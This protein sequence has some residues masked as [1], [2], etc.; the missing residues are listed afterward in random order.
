MSGP[1]EIWLRSTRV[2]R[3]P[4]GTFEPATVVISAGT[5]TDVVAWDAEPP[6][7]WPGALLDLGARCLLPGLINTHVHLEFSASPRPLGE[8][9][10]E[11]PEERLLRACGNAHRLL[12]SG[13]TT[14][15]DCGS[16]WSLLALARR[17]DLSPVRLPRLVCC[18]P[19]ITCPRGHLHM[20]GG[21]VHDV[22]EMRAHVA[23]AVREGARSVKAMASGGGMTPGTAPEIAS[24]TLDF[25]RAIVAEARLHALPGVAHVLATES[26]RR[27]ALAGFD[28]LE[29][30]AFF[31]RG[32]DGLLVRI[33]DPEVA[34]VVA[35][36]GAVV[37]ANLSTATRAL[38]TVR[39]AGHPD[40]SERHQLRQFDVMVENFGRLVALG[41]PI[42]C[43]TDAGVRD[44]PFEDTWREIDWLIRGGLPPTEALRAATSRAAAAIGLAGTV[45]RIAAGHAADLIATEDDPRSAPATLEHPP[46]LM[47]GG[48][49]LRQEF[50]PCTPRSIA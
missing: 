25:L 40:A 17:P 4:P 23:R 46:F 27:A 14:A 44:T 1:D 38:D 15:R 32:G 2:W 31:A 18:G 20:M 16:G 29:H 7:G 26:I 50:M 9:E 10:A 45:G 12:M 5:I 48:E 42:V 8:Y 13:V 30:C 22:A 28:S 43:G 3:D 47:A 49:I 24:F 21:E 19:P 33:Y 41:I 35:G 34:Q 6:A 37:M 36:S 11:T 39:A